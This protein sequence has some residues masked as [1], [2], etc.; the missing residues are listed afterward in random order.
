MAARTGKLAQE[1]ARIASSCPVDPLRPH[2]QLQNFLKSLSTHPRLTPAAVR[3]AQALERN[4]AHEKYTLTDRTLKPASNPYHYTRLV[5]GI[6]KSMKGLERP[7]WKVFF[8][9]W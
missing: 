7:R 8:G 4:E 6:E 2:I 3:A 5:E 9:I 1:M